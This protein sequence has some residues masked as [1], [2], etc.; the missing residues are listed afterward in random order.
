MSQRVAFTS[1]CWE[2]LNDIVVNAH[3]IDSDWLLNKKFLVFK[4]FSH[5][6]SNLSRTIMKVVREFK[7]E[8]K[9][10]LFQL[11]KLV[12]ILLQQNS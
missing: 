10:F 5:N 11:I 1:D 2:A 3:F 7:L 6:D 4:F 12:I 8:S 9:F